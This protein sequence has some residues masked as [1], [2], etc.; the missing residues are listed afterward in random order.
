VSQYFGNKIRG[1]SNATLLNEHTKW[2]STPKDEEEN[3]KQ[4]EER[5]K[6]TNLF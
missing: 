5:R 3:E 1:A 2:F 4:E 6:E